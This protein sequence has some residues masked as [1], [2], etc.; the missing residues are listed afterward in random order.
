MSV[1]AEVFGKFNIEKEYKPPVYPKDAETTEAIKNRMSSNF[2]FA[3]LNPKDRKAILDAIVPMTFKQ[4]DVVIKEGEDGDNFY[5]VELGRL[6]CS[7]RL[8]PNDAEDTFLKEYVPGE[9]FGE[10]A[11]LYNA[12]RAATIVCKSE[13]CQLWSL[14]RLTFN[15]IIKKAV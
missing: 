5:L 2:M 4:G 8:D 12:P 13:T 7:K 10:L 11:L 14:E 3:T 6:T 15:T 1:S 9:S